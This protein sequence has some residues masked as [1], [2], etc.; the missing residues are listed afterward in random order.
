MKLRILLCLFAFFS[1]FGVWEASVSE[2]SAQ[3][4]IQP[5]KPKQKPKPKPRPAKPRPSKPSASRQLPLVIQRLVSNMV[6]VEGGTF[7][8]GTDD[9]EG[10]LFDFSTPSHQVSLK[11]FYICKYEV[12]QAEWQAVMGTNPSS[13]RGIPSNYRN[14]RID[15]TNLPVECVSWIDCQEFIRKLNKMTGKKFRLPTEAE[16]EYAARGGNRS[17]GYKNAGGDIDNTAWWDDNSGNVT[18]PVGEKRANE[19]G[20]YDMSG[21]VWE[22]CQDWYDDYSNSS[23]KNPT[24]PITGSSRVQRGGAYNSAPWCLP[25]FKRQGESPD[26]RSNTVGLRLAL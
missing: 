4:V 21:N 5:P 14:N 20:L 18:H 13:N 17:K 7:T 23:Q 15:P 9:D 2:L 10:G 6:Y 22:W 19:L 25:V 8:M 3:S 24:G 12:T 16:W 1:T 11:G 26:R